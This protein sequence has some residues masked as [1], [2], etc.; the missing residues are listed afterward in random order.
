MATTEHYAAVLVGGTLYL[1]DLNAGTVIGTEVNKFSQVE[2]FAASD[3]ALFVGTQT[4]LTKI[5]VPN[6]ETAEEIDTPIPFDAL[7][8]M[9]NRCSVPPQAIGKFGRRPKANGNNCL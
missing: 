3:D 5:A 8:S 1:L 7:A 9:A 4:G 6:F 2:C